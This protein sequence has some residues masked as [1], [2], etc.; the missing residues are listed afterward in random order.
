MP[1]SGM[2]ASPLDAFRATLELAMEI[3]PPSFVNELAALQKQT[4]NL[5]DW[6]GGHGVAKPPQD[7]SCAS[8]TFPR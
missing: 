7:A 8:A 1:A 4:K 6:L 3:S 5:R 2:T